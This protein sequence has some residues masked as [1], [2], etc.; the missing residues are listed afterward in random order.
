MVTAIGLMPT[1]NTAK[2]PMC[3]ATNG[4]TRHQSI[5]SGEFVFS[6]VKD[7]M[8]ATLEPAQ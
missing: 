7:G 3:N 1:Q 4:D 6:G 8:P 5:A 2:H